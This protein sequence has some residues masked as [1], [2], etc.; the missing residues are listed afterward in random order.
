MRGT[1]VG[2]A[3]TLVL[4]SACGSSWSAENDIK[5]QCL[6]PVQTHWPTARLTAR[7][8]S[9]TEKTYTVT[10]AFDQ[11]N[12]TRIGARLVMIAHVL[13]N[14]RGVRTAIWPHPESQ[15]PKCD[16]AAVRGQTP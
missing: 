8:S 9:S 5:I 15:K 12:G 1:R 13:P 7:N 3:A 10:V 11:P 4:L 6:W 16:L 14:R 2:L